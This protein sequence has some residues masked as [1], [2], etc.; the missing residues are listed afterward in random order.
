MANGKSSIK[1][2]YFSIDE[3]PT[4]EEVQRAGKAP[5]TDGIPYG[6]IK[7]GGKELPRHLSDLFTQIWSEESVP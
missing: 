2:Q 5:G 3:V 1:F 7:Y 6:V 4:P